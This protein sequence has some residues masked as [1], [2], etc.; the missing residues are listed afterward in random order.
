MDFRIVLHRKL[1][2][3]VAVGVLDEQQ[4]ATLSTSLDNGLRLIGIQEHSVLV[5]SV[6]ILALVDAN[7]TYRYP[8]DF[9]EMLSYECWNYGF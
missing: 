9:T 1:R 3:D 5:T 4:L 2:K 8:K 6:Q 7:C